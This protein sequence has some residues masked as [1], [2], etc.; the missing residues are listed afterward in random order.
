MVAVKKL[1]MSSN[2]GFSEFLNE[3][4]VI[5]GLK[6]RNLVKLKGCCLG[7]GDQRMLVFEYV[8]NG[9]LAQVLLLSGMAYFLLCS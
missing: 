7:D 2:Q 9:N 8:E 1:T 6:H 3:V 5:S 4:V